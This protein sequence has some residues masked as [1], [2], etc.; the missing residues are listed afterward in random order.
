MILLPLLIILGVWI[1][2]LNKLWVKIVIT[3]LAVYS[4]VMIIAWW[5]VSNQLERI[6]DLN[7]AMHSINI[8]YYDCI[9]TKKWDA[10]VD[11]VFDHIDILENIYWE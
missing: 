8:D 1:P 4:A 5:E 10:R 11:C 3:V 6:D 7:T 2:A 9:Q